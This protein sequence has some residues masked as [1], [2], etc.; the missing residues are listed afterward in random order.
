MRKSNNIKKNL[1]FASISQVL[2]LAF[3][4]VVPQLLINYYGPQIHGLTATIASLISYL[5]LVESG[6]GAASVQSLYAP[7]KERNYERV[8]ADLNA[9]VIFYRRIGCIFFALVFVIAVLY[10]LVAADGLDY[11]LVFTLVLIS[12]LANTVEYFFTS[13]YRVLLQADK[14]LYV[15]NLVNSI[16]ILLQG[17]LRVV[18]IYLKMSI[19]VV[20]LVPAIVYT[21]R[22]I[23]ISV[24]VNRTYL[25]LDRNVSPNFQVGKKRW[26]VLIHQISNLVVNNTDN[27]VLSSTIGYTAVSIYGIY[28]MVIANI[29][30][31]LLQALSNAV[32]ANF[33]HLLHK[34]DNDEICDIYDKYERV[35]YY[36]IGIVFGI[37][38]F[39]ICPFVKLYVGNV[40][41]VEYADSILGILFVSVAVL[42][43]VRIPQLTIVTAAGHYKETQNHAIV[44]ALINI[45]VSII[46]VNVY[47][48]YGVLIGTIVSFL[49]RD[50]MFVWYTNRCILKR[51]IKKTA[52][53]IGILF[54]IITYVAAI[55]EIC[56]CVCDIHSWMSWIIVCAVTGVVAGG[57]ISV[58]VYYLDKSI[59]EFVYSMLIKRKKDN[60]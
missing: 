26:N 22:L 20:Q 38:S 17:T 45:V 31:F 21:V 25:Y 4:F 12:G 14:K 42:S 28:Q 2:T 54:C 43:N 39:A 57:T 19:F 60:K 50:V 46:L 13:K 33:G 1:I 23:I 53:N 41:G 58:L 47:G 51:S 3:A 7:L 11:W 10:P 27:I 56:Q 34:G 9:I 18:F 29:S 8:N 37:C 6:I 30:G 40:N 59:Y 52:K 49:Y 15:V 35:Y 32:T 48:I 44:E 16:G 24:Y 55:G 36:L 5:T